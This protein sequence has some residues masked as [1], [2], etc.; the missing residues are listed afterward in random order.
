VPGLVTVKH[1]E[2]LIMNIVQSGD[3]VIVV[4]PAAHSSEAVRKHVA[5]RVGDLP[6]CFKGGMAANVP[7]SITW[8]P[9]GAPDSD[10]YVLMII[11][12]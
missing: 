2:K 3:H 7:F 10:P 5:D 4:I 1:R 8:S 11:R 6:E 12:K 9:I